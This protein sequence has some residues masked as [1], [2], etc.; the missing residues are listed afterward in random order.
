MQKSEKKS[1]TILVLK[2]TLQQCG[3]NIIIDFIGNKVL[4]EHFHYA[5]SNLSKI[6]K[7]FNSAI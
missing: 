4:G 5:T 7:R 1:Q 2:F 6:L 3:K